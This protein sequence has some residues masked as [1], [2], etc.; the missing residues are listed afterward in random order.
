MF[1]DYHKGCETLAQFKGYAKIGVRY[2]LPHWGMIYY[3]LPHWGMGMQITLGILWYYFL[4]VA[5]LLGP[6]T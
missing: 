5:L 6:S 4:V 3:A 1:N 2:A